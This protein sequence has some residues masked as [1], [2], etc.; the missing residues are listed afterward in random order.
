MA[1]EIQGGIL[2]KNHWEKIKVLKRSKREFKYKGPMPKLLFSL[3][4]TERSKEKSKIPT[5]IPM[6]EL[7]LWIQIRRIRGQLLR[8]RSVM[9]LQGLVWTWFF[10]VYHFTAIDGNPDLL[11]AK[12]KWEKKE[13]QSL[14]KIRLL[15][16]QSGTPC[17]N[18][19]SK[20]NSVS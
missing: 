9:S 19:L 4:N 5:M 11:R 8:M 18:P 1:Q 10:S 7:A 3:E 12:R 16:Q 2:E 15:G 17:P 13:H 20:L 14:L 6:E